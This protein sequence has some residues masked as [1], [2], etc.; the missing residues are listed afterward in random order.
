MLVRDEPVRTLVDRKLGETT[1]GLL[2][3]SPRFCNHDWIADEQAMIENIVWLNERVCNQKQASVG[4]QS[5]GQRSSLRGWGDSEQR[6][7]S[8][9]WPCLYLW[10]D[11][12]K[13]GRFSPFANQ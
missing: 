8:C 13:K 9:I 1:H 2:I 7:F 6:L 10:G 4:K 3:Q 11:V 5:L 12:E